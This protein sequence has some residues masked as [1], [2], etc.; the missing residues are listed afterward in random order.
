[1]DNH[2]ADRGVIRPNRPRMLRNLLLFAALSALNGIAQETSILFIGN[3]YVYSNDLPNTLRQLALSLG[4]TV[5]VSSV[6]PGGYTLQQHSTNATTLSAITSTPWDHVVLQEQSQLPSFSPGQVSSQVFPYATALVDAVRA[7]A[8]CTMPVFFMT[9]GRQNGDQSNCASWPPV[10]TFEGMN[11][12]LRDRYV[13][14]AEDN[15]AWLA[16]V[17]VAWRT[18]REQHP[19]I[20]LYSGDGSHP[21]VA[22]T[23]LASCTF[24]AT[25]FGESCVG[26]TYTAGLP[27][28]TAAILQQIASSTVLGLPSDWNLDRP[29]GADATFSITGTTA[30]TVSL[31][32]PDATGTHLWTCTPG[33]SQT[34]Q[35][36]TF[37]VVEGASYTIEHVFTNVCG[38]TDTTTLAYTHLATGVHGHEA[39]LVTVTSTQPG[40]IDVHDRV[41]WFTVTDTQGRILSAE[42]LS[43]E[44]A[45]I[46]CTPG[47]RIYELLSPDGTRRSGRLVVW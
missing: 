26:A 22:G 10:C 16:P 11:D 13:Q 23:Y 28:A 19:T 20:E 29:Y 12:L 8:D 9:W 3:S 37:P 6:A 41:G 39:A 36:A 31:G 24:Y 21:S 30:T 17:G 5:V 42:R 43:G 45:R 47:V 14:M 33:S 18:V 32:H 15:D 40:F 46:H 4:D 7:N 1:M 2:S 38:D 34:T 35:N 25:F 27:V 44:R